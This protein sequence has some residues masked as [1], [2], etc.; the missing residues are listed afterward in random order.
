MLPRKHHM[1]HTHGNLWIGSR[2]LRFTARHKAEPSVQGETFC[3][4]ERVL[5]FQ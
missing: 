2:T 4:C 5:P 1:G 3:S